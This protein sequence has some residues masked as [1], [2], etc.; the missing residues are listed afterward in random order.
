MAEEHLALQ[1]LLF[2]AL[3]GILP[4]SAMSHFTIFQKDKHMNIDK[5]TLRSRATA[6]SVRAQALKAAF[7]QAAEIRQSLEL[8]AASI[9]ASQ[10]AASAAEYLEMIDE[11]S[12][13][14]LVP[15][16]AYLGASE[17]YLSE[18]NLPTVRGMAH[19]AKTVTHYCV[20]ADKLHGHG[21]FS[22][23]D[24]KDDARFNALLTGGKCTAVDRNEDG[25]IVEPAALREARRIAS[26]YC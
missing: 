14:G 8:S 2:D 25:K 21:V 23:H 11:S 7:S 20:T 4:Q 1:P 19:D 9:C 22:A 26:E 6:L 18:L 5:N 10:C 12:E 16:E 15:L 3:R 13:I 24:N 17:R